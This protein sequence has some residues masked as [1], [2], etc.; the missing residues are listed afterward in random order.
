LIIAYL[1]Q[2][3]GASL[4]IF[5]G[6]AKELGQYSIASQVADVLLIVPGSVGLVLYPMLVRQEQDLWPRVRSTALLTAASML[7]LCVGAAVLAP[8]ILPLVFGVQYS[9]A[10]VALWGLLPSVLAYSIVSVL[11][12]YL[13]ARNYPWT[14]VMAWI[15]GLAAAL[16]SGAAL[17]ASYGA[18]GAGLSQSCGAV[19]V[20][21]V[22][23]GIAKRR[24]LRARVAE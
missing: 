10:A 13:V 11:S 1:L 21:M 9:G 3:S 6:G 23:I 15:A 4:L 24:R 12:Q 5:A 18:V 2:R 8:L 7:V 22:I 19:L 20:C 14:V 17:T 16:L